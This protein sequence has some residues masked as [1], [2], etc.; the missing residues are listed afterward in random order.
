MLYSSLA[1]SIDRFTV[2]EGDMK[3]EF[4][5][6]HIYFCKNCLLHLIELARPGSP[7][8][9][10]GNLTRISQA[11]LSNKTGYLPPY[12]SFIQVS[13]FL[14]NINISIAFLF[15]IAAML[16]QKVNIGRG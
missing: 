5:E 8:S 3:T 9:G 10:L 13:D 4:C 14:V 11:L 15:T 7:G 12:T 6:S 2:K 16:V 1:V